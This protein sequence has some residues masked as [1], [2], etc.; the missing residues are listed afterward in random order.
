[1]AGAPGDISEMTEQGA[2]L[3][4]FDFG[5]QRFAFANAVQEVGEMDGVVELTFYFADDF[6]VQVID[7]H[8]VAGNGHGTFFAVEVDAEAFAFKAV[9]IAALAFPDDGFVAVVEGGDVEVGRL[10]IILEMVA[11][12]AAS[13]AFGGIH[14]EAPTGEVERMNAVVAEFARAPVPKPVP[15][16]VNDIILEWP[17]GRGS[18]PKGVIQPFRNR[19]RLAMTDSG[20]MVR[21]PG[22]REKHFA[23]LAAAQRGNRLDDP[24]PASPLVSHLHDAFVFARRRD[25]QLALV[26]IMAAGLLDVN[27][28]AGRAG[29]DCRGSMPVVRR[30]D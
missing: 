28:F 25:H 23:N 16:V 12:A 2:A 17:L 4:I 9:R 29:E 26:Q 3:A 22:T 18:L 24:W 11:I 10:P 15:I 8:I 1:M 5:V 19:R 14:G 27:V 30:G 21:V 20:T 13:D 7:L 6:A